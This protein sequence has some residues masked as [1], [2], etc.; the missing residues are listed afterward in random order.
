MTA[1]NNPGRDKAKN[2]ISG[3][4]TFTKKKKRE[5]IITLKKIKQIIKKK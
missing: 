5:K 2:L 4:N 3:D 1:G